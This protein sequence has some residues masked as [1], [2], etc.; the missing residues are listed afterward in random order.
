MALSVNW[1]GRRRLTIA[2]IDTTITTIKPKVKDF[3]PKKRIRGIPGFNFF[4]TPSSKQ[5]TGRLFA[6]TRP[7]PSLLSISYPGK[8]G[9]SLP[10]AVHFVATH[11]AKH[12]ILPNPVVP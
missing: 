8:R 4:G 12:M 2:V 6:S 5:D 10:K 9:S 7:L 3:D 1:P 11:P